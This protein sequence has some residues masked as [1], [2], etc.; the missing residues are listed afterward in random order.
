MTNLDNVSEINKIKA[1]NNPADGIKNLWSLPKILLIICG[2][3]N[4]TNPITPKKAT[5]SAAVNEDNNKAINRIF[6]VLIPKLLA[7]IS[8]AERLL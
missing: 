5:V 6:S 3:I 7:V 1:P 4:P 8:P 2:A